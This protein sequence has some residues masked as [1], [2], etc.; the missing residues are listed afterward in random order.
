MSGTEILR[1]DVI[2]VGRNVTR[3]YGTRAAGSLCKYFLTK[4]F[5]R[6]THFHFLSFILI[7]ISSYFFLD[8]SFML[9]LKNCLILWHLRQES[10]TGWPSGL[11]RWIKAP[12]SS[13]AWVRIPLQSIFF[14]N[15]NFSGLFCT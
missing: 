7:S 3:Y 14:N 13:G 12:I 4:F 15:S 6:A 10:K 5:A 2:S 11:R 9:K 1:N 8:F